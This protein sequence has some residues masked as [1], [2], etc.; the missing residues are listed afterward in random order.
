M[1]GMTVGLS[2]PATVSGHIYADLA[3]RELGFYVEPKI[4]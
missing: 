3:E 1:S 2:G 4:K